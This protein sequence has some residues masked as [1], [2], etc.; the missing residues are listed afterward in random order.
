MMGA[1]VAGV[2]SLNACGQVAFKRGEGA[3]QLAADRAACRIANPY[4]AAVHA[5]LVKKGWQVADLSELKPSVAG[6]V[7]MSAPLKAQ[8]GASSPATIMQSDVL[9]D[10][11]ALAQPSLMAQ[12][13]SMP[14]EKLRVG[15]WWKYGAGG[16]LT[17]SAEACAASLK[18][19]MPEPGYH[20]VTRAFYGC[21]G[22]HGWH[23]LGHGAL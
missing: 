20:V 3:G 7:I 5:C 10:P 8:T 17:E 21:M 15:S 12:P 6:Q 16:D 18:Q 14:D 19:A 9:K 23:G 22:T 13:S 4:P 2:L 11:P 1:A